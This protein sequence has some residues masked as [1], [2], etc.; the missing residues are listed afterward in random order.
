VREGAEGVR[1][2]QDEQDI[3]GGAGC[4]ADDQRLFAGEQVDNGPVT[5]KAQALGVGPHLG[6]TGFG[7]G[8]ARGEAEGQGE[9][10]R[11]PRSCSPEGASEGSRV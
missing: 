7:G 2:E 11:G 9:D 4:V 6:D 3:G 1:A 8:L 10:L 5:V